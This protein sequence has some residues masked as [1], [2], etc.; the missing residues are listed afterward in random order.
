MNNKVEYLEKYSVAPSPNRDYY[1][2]K[3]HCDEVLK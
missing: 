2:I 3:V 1:G